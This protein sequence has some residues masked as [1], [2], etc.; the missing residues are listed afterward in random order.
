MLDKGTS[1][2]LVHSLID[3]N[4]RIILVDYNLCPQVT[5]KQ[6]TEQICNFYKWLK[7]YAAATK[8]SKISICGHSAGAHLALQMFKDEFLRP[9]RQL[10][11]ID[12]L[13]LISGLYDLRELWALQA[14]NPQNI[15][16]LN[17]EKAKD[18]SPICW[19]YNEDLLTKYRQQGVVFH[20]LVAE[21]DSNTFKKQSEDLFKLFKAL[22]LNVAYKEFEKYDHFDIIEE[23]SNRNSVISKYIIRSLKL[24]EQ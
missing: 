5:L 8:A 2:H 17:A 15:L 16:N 9:L 24:I 20:V 1:G 14:S 23:C 10:D 13:F 3:Y 21:N 11:L 12:Q 6:I 7:N 19:Q 4:Y 22:G 18:L